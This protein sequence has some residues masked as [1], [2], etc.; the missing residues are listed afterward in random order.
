M[1]T[2]IQKMLKVKG[3]GKFEIVRERMSSAVLQQFAD[4]PGWINVNVKRAVEKHHRNAM[5]E[6]NRGGREERTVGLQVEPDTIPV[7]RHYG[8]FSG[9][10]LQPYGIS[11]GEDDFQY[12]CMVLVINGYC[13]RIEVNADPTAQQR[14]VYTTSYQ[15]VPDRI[16]G[17]GIAQ[18]VRD[19]ERMFMGSLRNMMQNAG[20]SSMPMGEVDYTR[21]ARYLAPGSVGSVMAN[22]IM[23]VDPDP[24]GGGRP[25]H[26]F[27]TVPSQVQAL[28]GLIQFFDQMA[29]EFSGLPAA[30]SGQPIGTG[31]NRTFRGMTQ[32]QG[33]A[34][35]LIQSAFLNIDRDVFNPLIQTYHFVNAKKHNFRGDAI[36]EGSGVAGLLREELARQQAGENLQIIAQ[37]SA[38]APQVVPQGVMPHAVMELLKSMQLPDNVLESP[39]PQPQAA[40]G[41][42]PPAAQ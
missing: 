19:I 22:T 31:A 10:E 4:K 1:T 5:I 15:D 25:A 17:Y 39:L 12:E 8:K 23:P 7:I 30:L 36:V 32:L 2:S 16:A 41:Q 29:D 33:N 28:T 21:I 3:T 20:A 38:S 37:L 24:V 18:L 9:K 42:E 26:M 40:G 27:H 14:R 6:M 34:M 11:M 13:C 35:K